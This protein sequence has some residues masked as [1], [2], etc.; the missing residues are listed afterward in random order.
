M[1]LAV[2]GALVAY[3]VVGPQL[4]QV[5]KPSKPTTTPSEPSMVATC[6]DTKQTTVSITLRNAEDE[7]QADTFDATG[8]IYEVDENG[9]EN[10]ITSITD[11]TAGTVT[12]DCGK[13]FILRLVSADGNK[14]DNSRIWAVESG[15]GA[16]ILSDTGAVK[17]T[18]TGASYT[19]RVVGS[20]HGVLEF[21]AKDRINDAFMY[22]SSDASNTDWELDGVT[23]T[24]TT[25]NSTATAV[26]T[27]GR[28]EVTLYYRTNETTTQFNLSLIHI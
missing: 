7:T 17:F 28:F 5:E 8:Y 22:D 27:G 23:F 3:S 18:T 9:K 4:F 1:F 26:G 2:F 11:T 21:R 25:D 12:L 10:Y 16:E 20:R 6:P 14:G 15:K 13:T 19:L 24:S